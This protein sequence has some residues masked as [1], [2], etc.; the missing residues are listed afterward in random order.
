MLHFSVNVDVSFLRLR[1][2]VYLN[3]FTNYIILAKI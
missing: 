2:C 3:L 1:D